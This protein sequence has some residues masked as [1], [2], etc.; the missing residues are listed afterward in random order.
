MNIQIRWPCS[1]ISVPEITVYLFVQSLENSQKKVI[2]DF[3]FLAVFVVSY[4]WELS[5]GKCHPF[6]DL[7]LWM[8]GNFLKIDYIVVCFLKSVN[9][10]CF[11]WV[12]IDWV[13]NRLDLRPAA[14]FRRLAWIQPVCISINVVPALKG[15]N[16]YVYHLK[17]FR[18]A[19]HDI[20]YLSKCIIV[21]PYRASE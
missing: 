3:L 21:I 12:M 7:T 14:E 4:H 5:L 8:L 19:F 10:A 9:A 18:M 20:I 16:D 13:A 17:L 15:L 2:K 1:R 6:S 11:L